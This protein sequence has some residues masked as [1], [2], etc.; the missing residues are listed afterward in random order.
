MGKSECARRHT[1]VSMKHFGEMLLG[2][3]PRARANVNQGKGLLA[4]H[5]PGKFHPFECHV[6][7]GR[8]TCRRF[9][10]ARKV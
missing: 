10:T 9:E 3:K 2:L 1:G 6:P 7:M 5:R 8:V 4:Q